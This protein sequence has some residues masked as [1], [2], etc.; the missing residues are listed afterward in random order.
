MENYETEN[1]R[2]LQVKSLRKEF[3]RIYWFLAIAFFIM[4]LMQF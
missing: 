4:L 2:L 3:L 1:K